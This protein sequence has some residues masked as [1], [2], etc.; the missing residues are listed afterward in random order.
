MKN[1]WNLLVWI[2][3]RY[4]KVS[5]SQI[6]NVPTIVIT[7]YES[8]QSPFSPWQILLLSLIEP[9]EVSLFDQPHFLELEIREIS[10]AAVK[11]STSQGLWTRNYMGLMFLKTQDNISWTLGQ[12]F[13]K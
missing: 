12:Y 6:S 7:W 13:L 11:N 10:A 4:N 9:A 3:C 2:R 8:C 5:N 1:I